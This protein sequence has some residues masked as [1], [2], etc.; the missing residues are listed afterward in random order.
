MSNELSKHDYIMVKDALNAIKIAECE[1]FVKNFDNNHT[2][3]MFSEHPSSDKIYQN[4]KYAGHSGCSMACTM[5]NAQYYLNNMDE[6]ANIESNFENI[7]ELPN[8]NID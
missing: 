4:I 7:P 1:D 5:R 6:W 8:T 3:F 2:G